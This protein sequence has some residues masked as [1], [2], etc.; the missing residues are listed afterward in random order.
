MKFKV[1][2]RVISTS[3]VLYGRKFIINQS[4]PTYYWASDL[5][6]SGNFLL[7]EED[8]E[9]DKKWS[10]EQKLKSMLS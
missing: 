1:G 4:F 2:D 5:D 3:G 10:R 6:N 9:L 8:L 7:R